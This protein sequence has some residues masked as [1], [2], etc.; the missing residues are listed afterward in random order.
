MALV[1]GVWY[2]CTLFVGTCYYALLV[3][4]TWLRRV[5][6]QRGGLYDTIPRDY[7]RFLLRVN[8]LSAS[9]LGLEHLEGARPC[10]FVSNHLSWI[11]V[12]AL[13]AV[14]PPP[15]RFVAKKELARVP[16]L[17]KAMKSAGPDLH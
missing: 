8:G 6:Y 13:V 15:V 11:D 5:P 12:L 1:R 10:V 3:I 16:I 2:V 17:G 14:I 9:A 4:L 7:G